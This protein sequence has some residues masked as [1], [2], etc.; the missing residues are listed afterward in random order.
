MNQEDKMRYFKLAI[1]V[2][3]LIMISCSK[4][5]KTKVAIMTKLDSASIVGSSEVNASRIFLEDNPKSRIEISSFDD[6]WLPDETIKQYENLKQQGI[7]IIITSHVSTC[8]VAIKDRINNDQVFAMVT[9]A[10]TNE[11]SKK[12]DMIIR[13]VLDVEKEQIRIAEFMNESLNKSDNKFDKLLIIR[14]LENEAYTKPALEVF[15]SHYQSKDYQLIDIKMSEINIS[16]L[17]DKLRKMTFNSL[18]L[19][20]GGYKT[21]C[22]SIAQLAATFKP[23]LPI[24]YT[25]W[26]KSPTLLETAGKTI[27]HSIIPSHYPPK[28]QNQ[29]VD[30][31]VEQYKAKF[32]T[33]PTFISLNVYSALEIINQAIDNGSRKP[34]QIKDYILKTKTFK[35]RFGDIVFDEFG[36]VDMPLYFIY[37]IKEEFLR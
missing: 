7:D 6:K 18:Y 36:D 14:D 21:N 30:Q 4:P 3:M 33:V 17:Q 11:L 5:S 10:T 28:G 2:L 25:P 1:I 20:I 27:E 22:G 12:K 31:Y 16:D 19:F 9:G 29:A 23:G 32:N 15:L 26:M 34:Q 8:I 24:M 13:N 37:D 35:T